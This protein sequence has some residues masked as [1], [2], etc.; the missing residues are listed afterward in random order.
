MQDI[1][2]TIW[3]SLKVATAATLFDLPLAVLFG[4][5]LARKKFV[6][7]LIFDVFINLPIVIPPIVTGY[8]LLVIF[9]PSKGLGKLI[10]DLTGFSLPFTWFAAALA[11]GIVAL[12]LCVRAVRVAIENIDPGLEEAARVLGASRWQ[13]FM[14][15]TFPLA[16]NGVV[17]GL[18]LG[19]AR[20]LGEFGATIMVAGSIPGE[21]QTIPL[22]IFSLVNQTGQDVAIAVLL[23]ISVLLAAASLIISE[24][25]VRKWRKNVDEAYA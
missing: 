1:S 6:G 25:L 19:F 15:V 17:A 12:P 3:L 18:V 13:V 16:R 24:I 5:I 21:T 23:I 20:C 22:A 4:Y 10:F 9:N 7:K 2:T 11:A 8:F 14:R